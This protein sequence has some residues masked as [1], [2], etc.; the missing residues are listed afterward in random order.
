MT[1]IDET[2]WQTLRTAASGEES[3]TS[4]GAGLQRTP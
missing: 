2:H 3:R 4:R 1:D